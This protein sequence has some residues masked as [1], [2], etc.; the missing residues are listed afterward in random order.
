MSNALAQLTDAQLV[1]AGWTNGQVTEVRKYL[2]IAGFQRNAHQRALCR[3]YSE[4]QRVAYPVDKA[5][6]FTTKK[7]SKVKGVRRS[8]TKTRWSGEEFDLIISLYLKYVDGVNGVENAYAVREAFWA[9]FPDRSSSA[10][11]LCLAQVKGQDSYH[12]AKGMKDT[13]ALLISKLVAI[14]PVRFA[15]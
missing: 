5:P 3:R 6:A 11:S 9:L 14:D 13:S 12:P 1:T 7:A 15:A 8:S 4:A 10:I 2:K